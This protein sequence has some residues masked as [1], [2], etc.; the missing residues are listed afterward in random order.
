MKT[1][2]FGKSVLAFVFVI[3]SSFT[4]SWASSR[5]YLYDTKE[6][7]GKIISKEIFLK[8][9]NYLNK[10]V[11]YEFKYNEAGQVMEKKA[12]RWNSA[13]NAWDN[14]Y[15]ITYSYDGSGDIQANYGM[16]NAKKKDF[17]LNNQQMVIP[18]NNYNDIFS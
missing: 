11:R 18:A 17:T 15:L 3:I 13:K 2:V 14:Y 1:S 5:D 12:Y 4:M 9:G 7:N 10:Q 16:W 6:E 8:D